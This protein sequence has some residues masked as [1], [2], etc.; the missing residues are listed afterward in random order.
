ME[1]TIKHYI[2]VGD[3]KIEVDA[4][5]FPIGTTAAVKH[6]VK[7]AAGPLD[8]VPGII[9][10]NSLLINVPD[11]PNEAIGGDRRCL[12]LYRVPDRRAVDL[13]EFTY[14]NYDEN[15]GFTG[16]KFSHLT[17]PLESITRGMT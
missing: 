4:E 12:L 16:I 2:E 6:A 3:E 11:K 13:F 8:H 10:I 1:T 15:I 7:A 9:C 5:G 17:F 14:D